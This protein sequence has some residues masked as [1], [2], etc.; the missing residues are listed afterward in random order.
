MARL[1]VKVVPGASRTEI[2]GRL[3]AAL[4]VRVAAPPEGGQANRIGRGFV[5]REG[6]PAG[7]RRLGRVRASFDVKGGGFFEVWTRPPC[8]TICRFDS[9]TIRLR[10]AVSRPTVIAHERG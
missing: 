6:R 9:C 2:V 4:K 1:K 3:G 10:D 5:G 7:G 8:V